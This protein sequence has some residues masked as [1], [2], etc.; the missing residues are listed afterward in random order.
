MSVP[1]CGEILSDNASFAYLPSG[2]APTVSPSGTF[3]V[4]P[5]SDIPNTPP[6]QGLYLLVSSANISLTITAYLSTSSISFPYLGIDL[7]IFL[8]FAPSS[9][10]QFESR[11]F[12]KFRREIIF[13]LKT[14][15]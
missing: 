5:W 14:S 11:I 13:W 9:P 7:T 10:C 1:A 15:S 8:S 4:S 12:T 2:V 3:A 6:R